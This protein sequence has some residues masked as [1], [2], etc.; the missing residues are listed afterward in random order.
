MKHSIFFLLSFEMVKHKINAD[1][2][3]PDSSNTVTSRVA[4]IHG[5]FSLYGIFNQ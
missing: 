1:L 3:L 2:G 4:A 5:L